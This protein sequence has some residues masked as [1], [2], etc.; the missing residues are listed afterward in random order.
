MVGAITNAIWLL[1]GAID[2]LIVFGS[3]D[4]CCSYAMAPPSG[5]RATIVTSVDHVVPS[6]R[7]P[8]AVGRASAQP[9]VSELQVD[10]LAHDIPILG[11]P[12][13]HGA[14]ELQLR[15]PAGRGD[16]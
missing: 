2:T 3:V 11:G 12:K 7:M 14:G 13:E 10:I 15:Y 1:Y 5:I 6:G 4:R 8:K 9:I 16:G